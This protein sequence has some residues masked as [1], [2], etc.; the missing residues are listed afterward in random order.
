MGSQGTLSAPT[1]MIEITIDISFQRFHE[2]VSQN[3]RFSFFSKQMKA[4]F[5][6]NKYLMQKIKL[7]DLL[8]GDLSHSWNL[9]S[10]AKIIHVI[11]PHWLPRKLPVSMHSRFSHVMYN[12]LAVNRAP[13]RS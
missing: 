1:A 2:E 7:K 3:K 12:C 6:F 11:H 9:S 13:F 4:S 8:Y 5:E 10:F